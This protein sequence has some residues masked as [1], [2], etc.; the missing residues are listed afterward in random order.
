MKLGIVV[1]L[2]GAL[3]IVTGHQGGAVKAVEAA[4]LLFLF[5]LVIDVI[6]K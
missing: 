6:R 2:L 4:Y 5:S 1:L 3:L